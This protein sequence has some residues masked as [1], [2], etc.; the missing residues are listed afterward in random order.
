MRACRMAG[1]SLRYVLHELNIL[2]GNSSYSVARD[3]SAYEFEMTKCCSCKNLSA[4]HAPSFIRA[5]SSCDKYRAWLTGVAGSARQTPGAKKAIHVAVEAHGEYDFYTGEKL[6]WNRINHKKPGEGQSG[7][8]AHKIKGCYPSADHYNGTS[9]AD[10][11][12]CSARVN[13]AKGS[14]T[15]DQFV[16][17]CRRVVE[18]ETATSGKRKMRF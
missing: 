12:I 11:R 2:S 13:W 17:L 3:Q 6:E 8:K 16:N 7:W 14:M 4:Y 10:F 15:H 5:S 9:L 1:L 18:N